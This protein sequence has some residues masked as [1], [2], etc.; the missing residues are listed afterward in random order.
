MK[1][2]GSKERKLA[3]SLSGEEIKRAHEIQTDWRKMEKSRLCEEYGRLLS[4]RGP[5]RAGNIWRCQK[6]KKSVKEE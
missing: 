4:S 6:T 2:K 5:V 3:V 1:E